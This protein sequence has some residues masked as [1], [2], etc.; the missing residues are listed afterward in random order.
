MVFRMEKTQTE[1]KHYKKAP[2]N[3]EEL[4]QKFKKFEQKYYALFTN[5][6]S[7]IACHKII[8]DSKR[9]PVNYI[10]TDVNP[11]YEKI[12]HLKKENVVNKTAT[13]L[14]GVEKPPYLDIYSKIAETMESFSFETYFPPM[15]KYFTVSVISQ[16][17]GEFITVFKDISE[18]KKSE[19]RL[20]ES[21][22]R[23]RHLFEDSPFAIALMDMKGKFLECNSYVETL[24]GYKKEELKEK[25]Y[26]FINL[27]PHDSLPIVLNG[28][29]RLSK[30]DVPEPKRVRLYKKDGDLIWV[31]LHTSLITLGE[32]EF[33]QVIAE[34]ITEKKKAE[35]AL[36]NSET[37]FR[38]LVE[39]ISDWIWEIDNKGFF[40]YSSPK[41]K[42]LLGY[43]PNE[44]IGKT[45][46]DFMDSDYDKNLEETFKTLFFS[47]KP[48]SGL[49]NRC[50]HK[51]GEI[52]HLETSGVPIFD[53]NGKFY[54]FRGIDR[55]ITKRIK[56]EQKLKESEKNYRELVNDA[57]SI[58]LRWD[59]KGKI[60][61]INEF[62]ETFL[63]YSKSGLVGKHVI[64][65][66]VPKTETT[67][68]DLVKLMED[69]SKNPETYKNNVNENITK[70]GRKV[71]ISWTNKAIKDDQGNLI[72]ILSVGNDITKQR[73]ATLK[74]SESEDKFR[75]ITE[76]SFIGIAI[77]EDYKFKY[78]NQ[79]FAD[80][81][82]FTLK[83]I[84]K[85]KPKEFFT[86]IHPEER[87]RIIEIAETNYYGKNE[88]LAGL[89]FRVIKKTGEVIWLELISKKITFEG[90]TA[91]L[92]STL[93]I[94]E[95][96]E[97]ERLVLEE[98][99][100]LVDLNKMRKD[101]ITRVSHELK[102]PL[103][104]I[105]GA[106]QILLKHFDREI[107]EGVLKFIE[108][109]HRGALRLKKLVENLI[110]ASRIESGKLE[111][112]VKMNDLVKITK[113]CVEEMSYL[114]DSR[115]LVL[116]LNFP[117]E[118]EFNVD[119]I[120]LQQVITNLLSNAIKNTPIGGII[121]INIVNNHDYTD[122]QIRD[123]GIGI[124]EKEKGLLF[125]KFGKMERYGMDLG[126]DI[127]GSGL[128]LYI[129][130][131]IVELHGGQILVESEGR[132][133]G[134]IFTIRLF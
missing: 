106:S 125:E 9:K 50:R 3:K 117:D 120:R 73:L 8:Y 128:G 122:I 25:N 62:G 24:L 31:L 82:G 67:G 81:L 105:Y 46:L 1:L 43:E 108:I 33:I 94:T 60:K 121:Y 111:L 110:D 47:Q 132:N 129:S 22:E 83:E 4:N 86:L 42:E 5:S 39:T 49:I 100:K 44:I 113:E 95:K 101:I 64:G 51:N 19:K 56:I 97:A 118:L 72:G 103:T 52:V 40:T 18:R 112:N 55:D 127:E 59:T 91:D 78:I 41:I 70:Y 2:F 116:K 119:K 130:K 63:G 58:I 134:S 36:R 98:N 21:V 23:Y 37:R 87:K 115:K 131:E 61:F 77:L 123:K 16:K 15:K 104:S 89:Q 13:E 66:I 68:R 32:E 17:I 85:W 93:D 28:F 38:A 99:R 27:V 10:I 69:I 34:N 79:Q 75:T 102:T 11:Q 54:G 109:F 88:V 124:T 29:K 30:G 84:L 26:K 7:A 65:T 92:I 71:W 126:V 45:P 90:K 76:Q 12:L 133:K 35:D 80:T 107:D 96:K 48:Y 20:I 14:Y 6:T 114:L 74:I 53:E 57:N